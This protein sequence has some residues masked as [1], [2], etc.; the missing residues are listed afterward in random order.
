MIPG[1]VIL[2]VNLVI[3]WIIFISNHCFALLMVLDW[4]QWA[5]WSVC[6]GADFCNSASPS[7]RLRECK[8]MISD[9]I[10]DLGFCT[11]NPEESRTCD[12]SCD[13]GND[14]YQ[15]ILDLTFKHLPFY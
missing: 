2:H 12:V 9:T 15:D 6:E 8:D 14:Y 13:I 4:G 7:T 1:H 3:K 5:D 11:G 10:V